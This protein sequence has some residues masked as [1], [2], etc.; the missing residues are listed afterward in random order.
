M[1]GERFRSLD[2]LRG[3]TI[4]AMT[5]CAAIGWHSDLPAWMFHCQVPPPDYAFHPEVRG[6]TWVDM[7][8]PFFLFTMGAVIPFSLGKKLERGVPTGEIL[9]GLAKRWLVLVG[10]S[11]V[12]GHA[13]LLDR[14][15]LGG[16]AEAG[17]DLALWGC[18][19]LALVRGRR[20]WLSWIGWGGCALILLA[21]HR[22]GGLDLNFRHKD[23]II[24][25][26][27]H[28]SLLAALV[29]LLTVGKPRVRAIVWLAIVVMKLLGWSFPQYLVIVLMATFV[30][31]W[32]RRPFPGQPRRVG[33]RAWIALA[34]VVVQ[35]W[36]LYTRHVVADGLVT[37]AL[38]TAFVL[39]DRFDRSSLSRIGM[40]GFALLL[41]GI[42]FDPIDGGIAKDYC[43]LCYLLVTGGQACLALYFVL[44]IERQGALSR[45][46][47]ATG[48]NPMIAYTACWFVIYPVLDACG[49]MPWFSALAE[50]SPALG[51]LQGFILTMLTV[52]LTCVCT[53]LKLFWRS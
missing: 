42:V 38:A 25:L 46:L 45:N 14:L 33:L 11:L 13:E 23:I 26:L 22:W 41:A 15:D 27:A 37:L 8:F 6:I 31:D 50:G 28:A 7:V 51:L 1:A 47:E 4:F 32:L 17:V 2:V 49:V 39:A 19:F 3:V 36:G 43:N 12:L 18:M 52:A 21:L 29:W 40:L 5:L 16:W 53:R 9:Q 10:F 20:K 48:Q 35:L 24:Y 44:W 34:A 30:G